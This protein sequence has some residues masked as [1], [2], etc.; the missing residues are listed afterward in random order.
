M[1]KRIIFLIFFIGMFNGLSCQ[2]LD[3]RV[4]NMPIDKRYELVSINENSKVYDDTE[5][6]R[7]LAIHR[8]ERG[9]VDKVQFIYPT[10]GWSIEDHS[11]ALD[12]DPNYESVGD[13]KW[14]TSLNGT[15]ISVIMVMDPSGAMYSVVYKERL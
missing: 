13:K 6:D 14:I 7:G 8:N 5:L 12:K 1:I 10:D 2:V 4:Q 15:L 11:T 3:K 9:M